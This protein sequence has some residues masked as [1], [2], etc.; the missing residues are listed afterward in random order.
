MAA[1]TDK[2]MEFV[3]RQLA[4]NPKISNEK[5]FEGARKID[6][7]IAN[8]SPRQFHAK[9]PLQVK[10]RKKGAGKGATRKASARRAPAKRTPAKRAPAKRTPAKRAPAKRAPAKRAPAEKTPRRARGSAS[11]SAGSSDRI[12]GILMQFA[13]DL[14][15][16][17]SQSDTID[18]LANMDRYVDR[19]LKAASR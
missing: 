16:A 15:A 6:E 12:R 5:L 17:D 3:E 11:A 13:K 7:A 9:Y 2:V 14:T 19:I 10:R 18:V 8:L 1:A 4:R